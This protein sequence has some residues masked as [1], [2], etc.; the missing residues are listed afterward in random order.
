M[1]KHENEIKELALVVKRLEEVLNN[2][3]VQTEILVK[4]LQN[5]QQSSQDNDNENEDL[6]TEVDCR[7]EQCSFYCKKEVTL[8]KHVNTKHDRELQDGQIQN[9]SEKTCK[10]HCDQC[11]YS[12]NSKKSLKNHVVNEHTV[13]NSSP[14]VECGK[15]FN[16]K[17][18][19][20][21]HMIKHHKIYHEV[22]E[23]EL[24]ELIAKARGRQ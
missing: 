19:L 3:T 22:D 18:N 21:D 15:D 12:C 23:A 11:K 6:E 14:C 13:Q 8:K 5:S 7:C 2:M 24:D 20:E 1:I 9:N 16:A 10:F 4:A 17:N